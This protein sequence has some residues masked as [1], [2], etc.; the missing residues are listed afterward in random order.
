MMSTS[1]PLHPHV[2]NENS[3]RGSASLGIS[4]PS[5]KI[6]QPHLLSQ[7][8]PPSSPATTLSTTAITPTDCDHT[9]DAL[10]PS[11]TANPIIPATT[12]TRTMTAVSPPT[13]VTANAKSPTT[14]ANAIIDSS[15]S[16]LRSYLHIK[17]L[18]GQSSHWDQRT[19]VRNAEIHSSH[20]P[21]LTKYIPS[22]HGPIQS[23]D[24]PRQRNAL[25][26]RQAKHALRTWRLFR[27]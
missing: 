19:G 4:G 6:Q 24:C 26:H 9:P 12:S 23:Q 10:S 13:P 27:P 11:I 2:T 25:Q 1:N 5:A 16:T 7:Q 17:H 14:L 15:L 8:K 21:P 20:L 3:A 22:T 18:P